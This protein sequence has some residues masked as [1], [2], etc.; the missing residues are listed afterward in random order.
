VVGGGGGARGDSGGGAGG[1]GGGASV[2]PELDALVLQ[3]LAKKP[4]DRPHSAAE[5]RAA[6]ARVPCPAPWTQER[7]AEWWR[8]RAPRAARARSR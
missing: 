7:A 3:C 2:P 8:E 1:S 4:N 6:L 5:L